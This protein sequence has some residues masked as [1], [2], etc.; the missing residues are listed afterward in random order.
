MLKT[1]FCHQSFLL[2]IKS[3]KNDPFYECFIFLHH[4]SAKKMVALRGHE[5]RLVLVT[6]SDVNFYKMWKLWTKVSWTLTLTTFASCSPIRKH[7]S[8]CWVCWVRNK[9]YSI[10]SGEN[11]T[12]NEVSGMVI[13]LPAH[14]S[15]QELVG[16]SATDKCYVVRTFMRS[17]MLA[18]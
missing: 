10:G 14:F 16:T 2:L 13:S 4:R 9:Q 11:I 17:W 15:N 5:N 7:R 6:Y 18:S 1:S 3:Y 8:E 12:T